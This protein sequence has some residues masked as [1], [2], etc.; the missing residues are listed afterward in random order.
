M[1]VSNHEPHHENASDLFYTPPPREQ[2]APTN[3]IFCAND[4]EE[5][6]IC[7]PSRTPSPPQ[8]PQPTAYEVSKKLASG[9]PDQSASRQLR[10]QEVYDTDRSTNS[11]DDLW[12]LHPNWLELGKRVSG[13][14]EVRVATQPRDLVMAPPSSSLTSFAVTSKGAPAVARARFPHDGDG[15]SH[16]PASTSRTTT[17]N[18]R[19]APLNNLSLLEQLVGYTSSDEVTTDFLNVQQNTDR[20]SDK[21]EQQV[22]RTIAKPK[23][24]SSPESEERS[25]DSG[26]SA[27]RRQPKS[28]QRTKSRPSKNSPLSMKMRTDAVKRVRTNQQN[29]I[30]PNK[31]LQ[32]E[33]AAS[34]REGDGSTIPHKKWGEYRTSLDSKARLGGTTM[35][36]RAASPLAPRA[37]AK[38]PKLLGGFIDDSDEDNG[39][40]SG[41]T[42][43]SCQKSTFPFEQEDEDDSESMPQHPPSRLERL[44][45][46]QKTVASAPTASVPA[47]VSNRPRLTDLM[48]QKRPK[49]ASFNG[50]E[51]VAKLS[52]ISMK[53]GA[54]KSLEVAQD[55]MSGTPAV[56]QPSA[57]PARKVLSY[58][59][60]LGGSSKLSKPKISSTPSEH[61]SSKTSAA[62]SIASRNSTLKTPI[63]LP[64]AVRGPSQSTHETTDS[65]VP[66]PSKSD[67]PEAKRSSLHPFTDKSAITAQH[68]PTSHPPMND[69]HTITVRPTHSPTTKTDFS[70]CSN[71]PPQIVP[72][73]N[74]PNT[75]Q[76]AKVLSDMFKVIRGT[77]QNSIAGVNVEKARN[78]SVAGQGQTPGDGAIETAT[79]PRISTAQKS[80]LNSA[81]AAQRKLPLSVRANASGS[82]PNRNIPDPARPFSIAQMPSIASVRNRFTKKYPNWSQERVQEAASDWLQSAIAKRQQQKAINAAA[83]SSDIGLGSPTSKDKHVNIQKSPPQST[84]PVA[85][86][87]D[88]STTVSNSSVARAK[89]HEQSASGKSSHEFSEKGSRV[90][91][92]EVTEAVQQPAHLIRPAVNRQKKL[93][94][95]V[96]ATRQSHT[97]AAANSTTGS[98]SAAVGASVVS[99][100]NPATD[101]KDM[102][103]KIFAQAKS[104]DQLKPAAK[105]RNVE[106]ESAAGEKSVTQAKATTPTKAAT[107]AKAI[108]QEATAQAKP[109]TQAEPTVKAKAIASSVSTTTAT[110]EPNTNQKFHPMS[111]GVVA[112]VNTAIQSPATVSAIQKATLPQTASNES[113]TAQPKPIAR[114]DSLAVS[115]PQSNQL[116]TVSSLESVAT[117]KAAVLV[118]NDTKRSSSN[119][120]GVAAPG[121]LNSTPSS[122]TVSPRQGP[123]SSAPAIPPRKPVSAVPAAVVEVES[124][125]R[126]VQFQ[127]HA[128]TLEPKEK[129]MRKSDKVAA[130][131]SQGV[132]T[133]RKVGGSSRPNASPPDLASQP[134]PTTAT[135]PRPLKRITPTLIEPSKPNE[136]RKETY[137]PSRAF[138]RITPT[139]VGPPRCK[140]ED[141]TY[142]PATASVSP[143]SHAAA[144]MITSRLPPPPVNAEP[145]FEFSIHRKVWKAWQ[146]EESVVAEELG[147][148]CTNIEEANARADKFF[149]RRREDMQQHCFIQFDEWSIR[150]DEHACKTFTAKFAPIMDPEQESWMKM[151]VQ[152]DEVSALAGG[153]PAEMEHTSFVSKSIYVLRLFTMVSGSSENDSDDEDA[154]DI[155]N[156]PLRVYHPIKGTSHFTT[157]DAANRAAHR[158]HIDLA[159]RRKPKSLEAM[160]QKK[161]RQK[162]QEHLGTLSG[163]NGYW[164]SEFDGTGLDSKQYELVVERVQ[165]YG[166]RNL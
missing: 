56:P 37:N 69:D 11:V 54:G 63:K 128:E 88:P 121:S 140:E 104:A 132:D 4:D 96:S 23:P 90:T 84:A 61:G 33:Q 16:L 70:T 120:A 125:K 13:L 112:S 36:K 35:N 8:E 148:P 145:Y 103:A 92:K 142:K 65:R 76:R 49:N 158:L 12:I 151:W 45:G 81:A 131:A 7:L 143:T 87:S 71:K 46:S 134:L 113:K 93:H 26:A 20:P 25:S 80:P 133:S 107:P 58:H 86:E 123:A 41:A 21:T 160:T 99:Q 47:K 34:V 62:P 163:N 161:E 119:G 5:T 126:R 138:T 108:T 48:K 1:L 101:L 135:K 31:P 14:I 157:L 27:S 102:R 94:D 109:A 67:Q 2:L 53:D 97:T 115:K 141:E 66:T 17:P 146:T 85:V 38:R 153:I 147:S 3:G 100:S 130:E 154:M 111:N 28:S 162:L 117:P 24:K 149:D 166:P 55:S 159:H 42:S 72:P 152:R 57:P 79:E 91:T 129:V 73:A 60:G 139:L 15:E 10:A 9:P 77:E 165:L 78:M 118:P 164:E 106:A 83:G 64:S 137:K 32:V 144:P 105:E 150:R 52:T 22:R 51:S 39:S 82:Q 40:D 116:P 122:P 156:P 110:S 29:S 98:Q 19:Q 74:R 50:S 89:Q 6:E 136:Q 95:I 59:T 68:K 127:R 43:S 30:S 114:P 155:D 75:T 44:I 124:E 18:H